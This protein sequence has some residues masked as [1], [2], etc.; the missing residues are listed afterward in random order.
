MTYRF[1]LSDKGT[2]AGQLSVR[3]ANA[4]RGH[5][6][7]EPS[8]DDV[9]ALVDDLHIHRGVVVDSNGARCYN[10]GAESLKEAKSWRSSIKR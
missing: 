6:R 1:K 4:L 7:S 5:F 8:V 3:A 9:A 2:F 10:L